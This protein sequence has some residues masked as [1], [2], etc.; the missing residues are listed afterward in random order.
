MSDGPR[1]ILLAH[2]VHKAKL[3]EWA[4]SRLQSLQQCR[5]FATKGSAGPLRKEV[6][7][8]VEAVLGGAAG[9]D[10]QLAAMV[11]EKRIDAVVL[12]ANANPANPHDLDV[13]QRACILSNVPIAVN[14][15]GADLLFGPDGRF[16]GKRASARL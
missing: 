10:L 16:V 9:G 13:L 2:D 6:G 12:L 3:I 11:I 4:R 15:A 14:T 5:V 7:L 8:E 1:I